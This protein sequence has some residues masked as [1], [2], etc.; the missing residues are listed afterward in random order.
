MGEALND[1][2]LRYRALLRSRGLFAAK[3]GSN[4][5]GGMWSSSVAWAPNRL[6]VVSFRRVPGPSRAARAHGLHTGRR[7]DHRVARPPCPHGL[8]LDAHGCDPWPIVRQVAHESDPSPPAA[9][10]ASAPL[11]TASRASAAGSRSEVMRT[12][13]IPLSP[14]RSV[15]SARAALPPP[16]GGLMNS[17]GAFRHFG[18][19]PAVVRQLSR[20]PAHRKVR[21]S[22]HDGA[23]I[24][25]T[26]LACAG[27]RLPA[28]PAILAS[29]FFR[30]VRFETCFER[31][32]GALVTTKTPISVFPTRQGA[33]PPNARAIQAVKTLIASVH[34]VRS[35]Q[36][37]SC[38]RR[39][40]RRT[41]GRHS[42][43][44]R[45]GERSS[46]TLPTK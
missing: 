45:L 7:S 42:P 13:S 40:S 27:R 1:P 17:T 38:R 33:P 22:S 18:R 44:E 21:A 20:G 25:R 3:V 11:A 46:R 24:R 37:A 4:T 26:D 10:S 16:E 28:H 23:P 39:G 8:D 15:T 36:V 34:R 12:T 32:T 5:S 2:L 35:S 41:A 43:Q 9:P 14:A 29:D 19:C 31:P 6:G 30:F